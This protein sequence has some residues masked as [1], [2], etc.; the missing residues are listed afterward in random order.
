MSCILPSMVVEYVMIT[1]LLTCKTCTCVP[2]GN[3]FNVCLSVFKYLS[4]SGL[5][6]DVSSSIVHLLNSFTLALLDRH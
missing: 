4:H 1:L 5:C 3:Q 6:V 2:G